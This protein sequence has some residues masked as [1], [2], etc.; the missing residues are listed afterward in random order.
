MHIHALSDLMPDDYNVADMIQKMFNIN[1][2]NGN[3]NMSARKKKDYFN[4]FAAR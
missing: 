2:G 1:N 4:I 3:A